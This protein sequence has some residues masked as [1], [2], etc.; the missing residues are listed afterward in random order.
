MTNHPWSTWQQVKWQ[1][2][3]FDSICTAQRVIMINL[4]D[5]A[6]V[7]LHILLQLQQMQHYFLLW[8]FL[9]SILSEEGSFHTK[10]FIRFELNPF[11][12][13]KS[14]LICQTV[15]DK[16]FKLKYHR[17]HWF[18]ANFSEIWIHKRVR[19]TILYSGIWVHKRVWVST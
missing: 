9:P 3:H 17:S 11:I 14:W 1:W 6:D 8:P 19:V 7:S 10:F 13:L 18:W 4:T 15:Y 5:G 12:F 2:L 16:I